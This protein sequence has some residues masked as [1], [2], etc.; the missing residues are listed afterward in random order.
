M[1]SGYNNRELLVDLTRGTVEERPLDWGLVRKYI[2]GRGLGVKYVFD[3]GPQVEPFSPENLL[4]IMTGPL[5]GTRSP[6]S[7]R[8]AVVTKSPLTGTVTDSHMGG[9]TAAR[10]KWAGVDNILIRGRSEK[11]V[12]LYIE[13]GR[14]EIRD[15]SDV[16]GLGVR[17]TVR[18]LRERHGGG[19]AEDVSVMAIGPAGERLVRFAS[20]INEDDRAAGRGG[21][22]AV[23]GYKRLKAIVVKGTSREREFVARDESAYHKAN[24]NGLRAIL[25]GAVTAP[26]KGGLSVYGTNVLMN[27]IDGVSGLPAYNA[28]TTVI[29]GAAEIGGERVRETILYRDHTC[30]ACPVGCKKDVVVRE[31]KY[32]TTVPAGSM[33][34]ESAWAFGAL[35]DITDREAVAQMIDLAN[36]FGVDT[37][38]TGNAIAVAMEAYE[39]GLIGYVIRWGDAD[40]AIE[41]L[42]SIAERSGVGDDLA[43]GPARFAKS[44]GAPEISLSV[45]GQSIPA[46]DPR[47]IQGIGLGYATSNRGACH[48]RG[49]T[50]SA[51]ILGIPY[52]V[53]RTAVAGKGELQKWFQDLFA[54]TD[55]LDVCKFST[56]SETPEHYARQFSALTGMEITEEELFRIGERIYNLERHYNNFAGFNR[57]EDDYLPERFLKEPAAGKSEGMVS[58]LNEMLDEYYR[59]RGWRDGVVPEEKLRELEIIA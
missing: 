33:E 16:W 52:P 6:M 12:Y 50:I 58:H 21:T 3:N 23:A 54:F 26:K 44:L 41:L 13:N 46:Y 48:L 32:R 36:E 56:F 9:W 51:E 5:T 42:R 53:D 59:V 43:E 37:I 30:H 11:P 8:L 35:I 14:A 24:Q 15:A 40:R 55:S 28:K 49:Y 25:Q 2:G 29:E 39:R 1:L 7:G 47:A 18:V 22:G 10:I 4:A 34:Y 38:E 31:G 45:K 17:E 19:R 20:F 57:R 27:I